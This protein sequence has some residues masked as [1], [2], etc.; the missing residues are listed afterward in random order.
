MRDRGVPHG[1]S[2]ALTPDNDYGF[3]NECLVMVPD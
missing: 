1:A 2:V 3:V